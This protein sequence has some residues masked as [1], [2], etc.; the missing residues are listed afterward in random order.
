MNRMLSAAIFKRDESS[1]KNQ[2]I[3][4][5][6]I[7]NAAMTFVTVDSLCFNLQYQFRTYSCM[8]MVVRCPIAETIHK[9][10]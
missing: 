4:E 1:F 9:K 2:C 8:P 7:Y 6:Y 5:S 10:K 3:L